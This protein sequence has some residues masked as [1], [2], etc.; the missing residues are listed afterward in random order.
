MSFENIG[1]N[2]EKEEMV[3]GDEITRRVREEGMKIGNESNESG[4]KGRLQKAVLAISLSLAIFSGGLGFEAKDAQAGGGGMSSEETQAIRGN[5]DKMFDELESELGAVKSPRVEK[6]SGIITPKRPYNIDEL[7]DQ[8]KDAKQTERKNAKEKMGELFNS[9]DQNKKLAREYQ[10]AKSE[11]E[12]NGIV[13]EV[14][15]ENLL[16]G[17][18][19]SFLKSQKEG[20]RITERVNF[21]GGA[22]EFSFQ[23]ISGE[24]KGEMR[25]LGGATYGAGSHEF[26]FHLE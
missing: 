6:E 10:N 12:R 14:A 23:I 9:L 21:I 1:Q 11:A 7:I 16:S 13:K 25:D 26:S 8:T 15:K 20:T 19:Y 3:E 24:V 2:I 22:L 18:G 5:S 4:R 17:G